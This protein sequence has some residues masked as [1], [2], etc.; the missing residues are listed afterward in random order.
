MFKGKLRW[1]WQQEDARCLKYIQETGLGTDL[2]NII[3]ELDRKLKAIADDVITKATSDPDIQHLQV[4]LNSIISIPDRKNQVV[5][6]ML[7]AMQKYHAKILHLVSPTQKANV[8]YILPRF[9]NILEAFKAAN[10][11]IIPV[12]EIEHY[13]QQTSIDYLN[14]TDKD[15]NTGFHT[16]RD[17]ILSAIDPAILESQY[18][19]LLEILKASVPQ[20]K[21]DL[22]KHLKFQL[23][24]WIQTVQRAISKGDISDIDGLKSNGRINYKLYNQLFQVADLQIQSDKRFVCKLKIN[25]SISVDTEEVIFSEET[26]VHDFDLKL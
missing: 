12:G 20:I 16:E 26:I 4:F 11:F 21:V 18:S 3:G 13:Y 17:Y 6:S 23:V 19:S 24:E 2:G 22:S 14:F 15:K 7:I 10:I 25:K 5:T 1:K 8:N 9:K